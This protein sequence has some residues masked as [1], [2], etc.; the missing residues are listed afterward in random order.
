MT[1]TL[2][3]EKSCKDFMYS[4]IRVMMSK[5]QVVRPMSSLSG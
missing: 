4:V 3:T 1:I 2:S 5:I